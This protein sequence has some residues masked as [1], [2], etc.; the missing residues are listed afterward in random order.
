M[1]SGGP[2]DGP[3]GGSQPGPVY[4]FGRHPDP[5]FVML[6]SIQGSTSTA[7]VPTE[8]ADTDRA[9]ISVTEDVRPELGSGSSHPSQAPATTHSHKRRALALHGIRARVAY[10]RPGS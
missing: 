2:S 8:V 10:R 7:P 3:L 1:F 6:T 9:P 4:P 5:L